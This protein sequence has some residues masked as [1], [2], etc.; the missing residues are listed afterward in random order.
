MQIGEK[1][2]NNWRARVVPFSSLSSPSF[3]VLLISLF[4]HLH[5]NTCLSVRAVERHSIL[6][7]S[8]DEELYF[9]SPFFYLKDIFHSQRFMTYLSQ[10]SYANYDKSRRHFFLFP[11]VL[12]ITKFNNKLL[13]DYISLHILIPNRIWKIYIRSEA[14]KGF[15]LMISLRRRTCVLFSSL[16]SQS[17]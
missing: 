2:K 3:V 6:T 8:E 16:P 11:R 7:H 17:N 5:L 1:S 9:V 10:S 4:K 14:L 13:K 12:I 15:K